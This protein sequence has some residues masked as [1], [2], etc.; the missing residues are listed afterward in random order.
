VPAQTAVPLLLPRRQ[1][2]TS[3]GNVLAHWV[4]QKRALRLELIAYSVAVA[5]CEWDGCEDP[6]THAIE[7]GFPDG[8]E[9]AWHVCRS[10][11]RLLKL[12]VVRSRPG[13]RPHVETPSPATVQCGQCQRPLDEPYHLSAEDAGR[14]RT[15]VRSPGV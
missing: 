13:A 11:D 2:R 4:R 15:A 14:A 1:D 12:Q 6:S 10:H 9:E 5:S 8:T 7:I 3:R